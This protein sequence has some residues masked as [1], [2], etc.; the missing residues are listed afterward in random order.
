MVVG[1]A[2]ALAGL[3][4]GTVVAGEASAGTSKRVA[5]VYYVV[6]GDTVRLKSGRYVRL[7]GYDTPEGGKHYYG[8]AKRSLDNFI[9]DSGR[10]RLVNPRRPMTPITTA[11]CSGTSG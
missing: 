7:I 4:G 6:D 2:I 3:F 9:P 5:Y 1:V 10:I 8:K 11:A